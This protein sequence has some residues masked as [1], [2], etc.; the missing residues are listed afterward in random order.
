MLSFKKN[1]FVII[2]EVRN[3]IVHLGGM[4]RLCVLCELEFKSYMKKMFQK[5]LP[6]VSSHLCF[7]SQFDLCL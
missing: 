6:N 3:N 2:Y 4:L 5:L 1:L 7:S